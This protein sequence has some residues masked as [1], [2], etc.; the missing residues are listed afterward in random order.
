M[1]IV[2]IHYPLG[3]INPN[4]TDGDARNSVLGSF[5]VVGL[6]PALVRSRRKLV[7]GNNSARIVLFVRGLFP[8]MCRGWG[9][10]EGKETTKPRMVDRCIDKF[11]PRSFRV[12]VFP[13]GTILFRPVGTSATAAK[14]L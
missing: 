8:C 4:S 12:V 13:G 6:E 10:C 7:A 14:R 5:G 2:L 11:H 9:L 3:E 1:A